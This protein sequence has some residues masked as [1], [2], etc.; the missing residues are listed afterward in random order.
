M[1]VLS[2]GN[3]GGGGSLGEVARTEGVD[4]VVTVNGTNITA[5]G[6][7]VSYSA[8]GLSLSFSLGTSLDAVNDTE[9][10]T[11]KAAGG[12]SFQ[13]GVDSSTT[14]TLGVDSL[15]SYRLGG[16]DAG[17]YL[18]D[19][20]SGGS[21]DLNSDTANTLKAVRKAITQVATA[22][23]RLGGFQKF[24]IETSINS[25]TQ[26]QES[27]TAAKSIIADTDYATATAELNRQSVLLN[28]GISLLGLANQ[29]TSQILALLA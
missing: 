26:M 19:L 18:T 20:K 2:G 29:Q 23:G 3:F 24:Q 11:V 12:M 25:L 6:S 22:R 27:L 8:N 17:A 13:L 16:G 5:D 14:N 21:A 28:S 4:A 10:F 9:T 7:D 15:A 1:T